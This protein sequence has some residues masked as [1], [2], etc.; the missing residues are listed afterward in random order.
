MYVRR[1]ARQEML[2]AECTNCG[3]ESLPL[4]NY[5]DS[6]YVLMRC[7]LCRVERKVPFTETR[8]GMVE[9]EM[10]PPAVSHLEPH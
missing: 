8:M 7:T 10:L 3:G 2:T 5:V 6:G 9:P 1:M 4:Q